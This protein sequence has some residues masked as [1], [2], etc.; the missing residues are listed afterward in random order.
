MK[1]VQNLKL[2]N[3]LDKLKIL[4]FKGFNKLTTVEL[5]SM[6]NI[7]KLGFDDMLL[8]VEEPY[9]TRFSASDCP[10]ISEITFNV[11]DKG[12][13]IAFA[14]DSVV[15]L[16][17]MQSVNLI[18]GN[19]PVKGLKTLIVPN[20]TKNIIFN[21]KYGDGKTDIKNIWSGLVNH[22]SDGYVG[23]DLK[24]VELENMTMNAFEHIVNGMNFNIAPTDINPFF[25]TNRDG[26]EKPFFKPEGRINLSKYTGSME[27][28]FKG[29]DMTKFKVVIEGVRPQE[30]LTN[31]FEQAKIVNTNEISSKDFVNR[32]LNAFPYADIW[33][34]LFKYADIDFDTDDIVIPDKYISTADMY[35][36][37]SIT[38]DIDIPY[39]MINVDSMFRDCKQLKT[40]LENWNKDADYYDPEMITRGCYF[41]SGGDL[42][43]VPPEWGGYGFYPEVTS[44][45]IVDIPYENY[46]LQL[47]NRYTTLSIGVA[48]WGD[49]EV[50]FLEEDKYMHTYKQPGRYTIKGHFIFGPG[51]E[52]RENNSYFSPAESL[53]NV[54]TEVVYLAQDTTDLYQAFKYCKN[55][56]RVNIGNLSITSLGETFNGCSMLSD[57]RYPASTFNNLKEIHGMFSGCEL[58]KSVDLSNFNT[59]NV[60]DFS[61]VFANCL[62]L[63]N[64]DVSGFNT[65][66]AVT[67]VDM[68]KSCEKI[69]SL[70]LS[71]FITDKVENMQGMFNRCISLEQLNISSFVT[72]KVK[73]MKGMFSRTGLIELDL[74]HF[75]TNNVTDMAEMFSNMSKLTTLNISS[76]NTG[77]VTTT[78]E[79]FYRCTALKSLDLTSFDMSNVT[80]I[81]YM[82][83][84][85]G[86]LEE[87]K[88]DVFD[89]RKVKDMKYLFSGCSKLTELNTENFMIEEATNIES[90]FI[91]CSA[92]TSLSFP[93]FNTK[94]VTTMRD[95]FSG[96]RSLIS[97]DVSNFDTSNCQDFGG[98]FYYCPGL[99]QIDVSNF[100]TKK[101][102]K[103]DNM[104]K[105][106]RNIK[107]LDL[108]NFET[109]LLEN[110]NEMFF[111][112]YG[113]VDVKLTNFVSTNIKEARALF[114]YC[115][116]L[117]TIDFGKLD[118]NLVADLSAMFNG[119]YSLQDL[120]LSQ[121]NTFSVGNMS[122]MFAGCHALK[123]LILGDKFTTRYVTNFS[124]MFSNTS[125][126]VDFNTSNFD[127]SSAENLERTFEAC[128][129]NVDMSNEDLSRVTTMSRM[130]KDFKGSSINMANCDVSNSKDNIEFIYNCDSLVEFI[131]PMNISNSMHVNANN[132]P[133][134]VFVNVINNLASVEEP[135]ILSIGSV[136]INKIPDDVI[137]TAISKNW[138]IA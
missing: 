51:T 94:N 104:F 18:T 8:E 62:S 114:S 120:D 38:K 31:L 118:F 76:F 54:L 49:G 80:N 7:E 58:L 2:S 37:T 97:I 65:K 117:K 121:I 88:L 4:N 123:T 6:H 16:S 99:L 131:P 115:Q 9:L 85:N 111:E 28:M 29:M 41:N 102:K 57:L 47:C 98:V 39:T 93:K 36:G 59:E 82:F 52:S 135:Q 112:C 109:P 91:N 25:N 106:C 75:N 96:C 1:Y 53:R 15:D 110:M 22:S 70:D 136:N 64:V 95:I 89:V 46:T 71:N 83:S 87:L 132:L 107:T 5:S 100:N 40:Y 129:F 12:N 79:M 56:R 103:M 60:T 125:N 23:I 33:D 74:S 63:E 133:A 27:Y 43:L 101:A 20:S 84:N 134:E 45:I 128:M 126:L 34:G 124:Y 92:L 42:E 90:M 21:Y 81:M 61:N 26:I 68:F 44:E 11:S 122:N 105:Y 127:F 14:P 19:Y 55:L 119:C 10:R 24:G 35:R 73:S 17:G 86:E 13:K 108:T 113:L 48:S 116:Q 69:V 50:T 30:I 66:N 67:M 72:D 77:K 137:T 138:S 130:F 3:S 78:E 32:L